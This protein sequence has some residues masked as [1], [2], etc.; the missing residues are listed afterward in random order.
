MPLKCNTEWPLNMD[1]IPLRSSFQTM[2]IEPWEIQL[3]EILSYIQSIKP[4]KAPFM[5]VVVNLCTFPFLKKLT[6][7][8]VFKA[9]YHLH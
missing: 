6:Q 3:I 7:S 1:A 4:Y 8:F 5:V 2:E 9:N